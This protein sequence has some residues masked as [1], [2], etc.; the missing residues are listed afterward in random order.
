MHVVHIG[1][2]LLYLWFLSCSCVRVRAYVKGYCIN[3]ARLADRRQQQCKA[4]NLTPAER[5][6]MKDQRRHC[7][8]VARFQLVHP[9][10]KNP[11][12]PG[13]RD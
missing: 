12:R 8:P 2:I 9:V 13:F 7:A 4:R 3:A 5:G 1:F 11:F 6:L 10:E